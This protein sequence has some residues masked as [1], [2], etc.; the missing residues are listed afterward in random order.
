MPIFCQTLRV[1]RRC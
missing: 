1:N